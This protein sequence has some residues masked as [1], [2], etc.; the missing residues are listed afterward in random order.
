MR[1]AFLDELSQLAEAFHEDLLTEAEFVGAKR[2]VVY[3]YC[4]DMPSIDVTPTLSVASPKTASA[5][6][7]LVAPS[8]LEDRYSMRSYCMVIML[9]VVA[10]FVFVPMDQNSQYQ[11]NHLYD[12]APHPA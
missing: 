6:A 4:L 12:S 5:K 11:V 2:A 3:K 1:A 7:L 10:A 8:L 9:A